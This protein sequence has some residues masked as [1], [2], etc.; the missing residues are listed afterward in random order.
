MFSR[1]RYA[2]LA[3]TLAVAPALLSASTADAAKATNYELSRPRNA[4]AES[5]PSGA[6]TT[7]KVSW[8][9]P[10]KTGKYG[11]STYTV[12]VFE[13]DQNIATPAGSHPVPGT[14]HS[15][16]V[17]LSAGSYTFQVVARSKGL[18][19]SKPSDFTETVDAR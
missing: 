5:G 3:L 9:T 15:L 4:V 14:K 13:V 11:I 2:T 10:M 19:P 18:K 7:V 12:K 1:R 17:K 16:S 6:P 8:Q